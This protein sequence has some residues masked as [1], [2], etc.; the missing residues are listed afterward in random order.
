M[1]CFVKQEVPPLPRRSRLLESG[2]QHEQDGVLYAQLR[3]HSPREIPRFQHISQDNLV[4]ER[5]ST[6]GQNIRRCSP[7]SGPDS[8]YSVLGLLENKSRSLPLLG[9]GSDGEQSYRLS[10]P[11]HTPPRLSPKP[12]RQVISYEPLQE[13]THSRPS[14]PHSLEHMSNNA[15]YHLAGRP[16]SPHTT[17]SDTRS[18]QQGDSLYAEVP[19]D[20]LVSHFPHGN[21]YKLI[22]GHEDSP[23]PSANSNTYEPLEDIRP[24]HS[25]SSWG[26]KV[27]DVIET[28]SSYKNLIFQMLILSSSH[29]LMSF[30]L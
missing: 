21:T 19:S 29:L 6:Q 15:V 22:P 7:P 10:A 8:V 20:T 11:P 9:I 12:A 3:G 2:P 4:T 14:S 27:S 25:Q 24:K 18:E 26:F 28:L 23:Q 5:S 13:R 30:F 1:A 16:G 17:P